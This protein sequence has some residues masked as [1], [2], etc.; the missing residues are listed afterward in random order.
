MFSLEVELFC[1]Q[2]FWQ[3]FFEYLRL[4]IA[5]RWSGFQRV[6]LNCSPTSTQ[7]HPPPTT[8]THLHP[9]PP[10]FT[11]LQKIFECFHSNKEIAFH[12]VFELISLHIL[13]CY[14]IPKY[15]QFHFHYKNSLLQPA[16][17]S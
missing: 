5:S 1:L 15:N 13:W 9:P 2:I 11:N 10:T 17:N 3:N 12:F 14:I 4:I 16:F 8:F 6:V 7:L